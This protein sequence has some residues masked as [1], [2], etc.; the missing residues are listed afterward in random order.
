MRKKVFV[1]AM[2]EV[3]MSEGEDF[4]EWIKSVRKMMSEA[5]NTNRISLMVV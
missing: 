2:I 1:S 3:E 5:L 4:G